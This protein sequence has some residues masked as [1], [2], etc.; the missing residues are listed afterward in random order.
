MYSTLYFSNCYTILYMMIGEHMQL[1]H[2]TDTEAGMVLQ[3][4]AVGVIT[5]GHWS[6]VGHMV[7]SVDEDH[8][9]GPVVGSDDIPKW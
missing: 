9:V 1:P 6:Y 2:K 8:L 5:R 7:A 3:V 4:I